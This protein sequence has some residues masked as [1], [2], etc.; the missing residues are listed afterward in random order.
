VRALLI[1]L[2]LGL[3]A[4]VPVYFLTSKPSQ[5]RVSQRIVAE[6]TLLQDQE[7]EAQ[8]RSMRAERP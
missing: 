6:D 3:M 5:A 8:L 4:I 1:L 7:I 2:C